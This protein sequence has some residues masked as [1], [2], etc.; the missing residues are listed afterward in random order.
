GAR[1]RSEAS[2]TRIP[3]ST[4]CGSSVSSSSSAAGG[5][6]AGADA[7]PAAGACADPAALSAAGRAGLPEALPRVG[8]PSAVADE[9]GRA[10]A[11]A[12]APLVVADPSAGVD[13]A[14]L[15]AS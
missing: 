8:D 15:A 13:P 1:P 3:D 6:D 4:R 12:A 5:R 10:R 2:T 11:G 9:G 14:A 7:D